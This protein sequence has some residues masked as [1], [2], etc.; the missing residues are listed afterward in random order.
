MQKGLKEKKGPQI[1]VARGKMRQ[2]PRL[3]FD[4]LKKGEDDSSEKKKRKTKGKGAERPVRRAYVREKLSLKVGGRKSTA[5]LDSRGRKGWG[6]LE[7]LPE[8]EKKTRPPAICW[9]AK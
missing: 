4:V 9:Y 8:V 3:G 7:G 5:R 6:P 2:G 1:R